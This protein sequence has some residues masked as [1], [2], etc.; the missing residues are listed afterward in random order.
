MELFAV[1]ICFLLLV[2]FISDVLIIPNVR[3]YNTIHIP[4]TEF[5][6][7]T[8]IV[9]Q[10]TSFIDRVFKLIIASWKWCLPYTLLLTHPI[11]KWTIV[12][13]LCSM[14]DSWWDKWYR[15]KWEANICCGCWWFWMSDNNRHQVKKNTQGMCSFSA[16]ILHLVR[17]C[18][19]RC[20]TG[21]E[22]GYLR[23][24][25]LLGTD[26]NHAVLTENVCHEQWLQFKVW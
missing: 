26:T 2:S 5:L 4:T 11:V 13:E 1:W 19:F 16:F 21:W 15:S 20:R 8:P 23:H 22:A 10:S 14:S 18:W 24:S 12:S 25:G 3:Y 9:T 7:G 17:W 6:I